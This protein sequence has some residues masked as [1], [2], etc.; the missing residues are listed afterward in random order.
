MS[1]LRSLLQGP[2]RQ[3]DDRCSGKAEACRD[4]DLENVR[5]LDQIPVDHVVVGP[6]SRL[7]YYTEPRSAAAD[8]FRLMRMRLQR[9]RSEG[10]VRKVLVTSP[11]PGDGKSTIALNLATALAEHGKRAVVLVE[12][13]LH[14][15]PLSQILGLER[16]PG[17]TACL[18]SGVNPLGVV[19]RLVPLDW[20]LLRAG[21]SAEHPTDLLHGPMLPAVLEKLAAYFD[22]V[23][24]DSP[25][26]MLLPEVL[27]LKEQS[28]V[29]LLV[30][31]ASRTSRDAVE[32]AITHLGKNHVL[33]VILNGIELSRVA[34]LKYGYGGYY[35][36]AAGGGK[37]PSQS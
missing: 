25:P 6:S 14:H 3:E 29:S 31:R 18:Q 8:C 37:A 12:A 21:E 4:T 32:D 16:G 5:D 20:Y 33:G 24:I 11:L 35:Y 34:A 27:S 17:L 10:K 22:W 28:D 36:D 2:N 13:D 15:S 26:V 19:R 23:V 9:L 7:V 30:A 1:R